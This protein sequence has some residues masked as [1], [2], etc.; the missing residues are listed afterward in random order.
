MEREYQQA[1][2]DSLKGIPTFRS[3]RSASFDSLTIKRFIDYYPDFT[4]FLSVKNRKQSFILY[5]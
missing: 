3:A 4:P 2:I 1:Y 5:E